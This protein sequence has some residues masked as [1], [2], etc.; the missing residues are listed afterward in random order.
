MQEATEPGYEIDDPRPIATEAPYTYFLPSENELLA[1]APG[2]LVKLIIRSIPPSDEYDAERMWVTVTATEPYAMRGTLGNKPYDMPHLDVGAE[3]VF[4]RSDII[5]ILWDESRL[6]EPPARP[7][8]REYW[9][10]CLVETCVGEGGMPVGYL[11]REEP[12]MAEEGDEFPDSGWRIRGDSR[13]A[14]E[15]E[16]DARTVTYVALGRVLNCDDSWLHLIDA[17]VGSSF[18]RNWETGE[19]EPADET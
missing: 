13:G 12:D 3:I 5:D 10:R 1:V 7:P 11:Y 4:C 16:I 6:V 9:E 17:P 14:T 18:L 15:E 19:F 8:R 2:D